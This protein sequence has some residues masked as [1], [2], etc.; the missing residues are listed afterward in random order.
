GSDIATKM[1]LATEKFLGFK[2]EVIGIIPYS[3]IVRQSIIKQEIFVQTDPDEEISQAIREFCGLI[4]RRTSRTF[5]HT[6]EI[7]N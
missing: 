6:N 1:N 3:R 5:L 7:V 2:A 4:F